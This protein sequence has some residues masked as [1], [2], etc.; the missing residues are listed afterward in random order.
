MTTCSGHQGHRH[1]TSLFPTQ[2]ISG[3]NLTTYSSVPSGAFKHSR[4]MKLFPRPRKESLASTTESVW[5]CLRA[6][7]LL[8]SL[9][10]AYVQV[11]DMLL[12]HV[13]VSLFEGILFGVGLKGTQVSIWGSPVRKTDKPTS[14]SVNTVTLSK[15]LLWPMVVV[16]SM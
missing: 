12:R 5:P 1:C 11:Q 4:K 9:A 10:V 16:P 15:L 8:S 7:M 2:N 3:S 6:G 14:E 13:G